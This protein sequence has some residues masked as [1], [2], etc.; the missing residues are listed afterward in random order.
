[1][2]RNI[3]RHNTTVRVVRGIMQDVVKLNKR[4]AGTALDDLLDEIDSL[5]LDE[6]ELCSHKPIER[7]PERQYGELLDWVTTKLYGKPRHLRLVT[8]CGCERDVDLPPD[9]ALGASVAVQLPPREFLHH[10]DQ[11]AGVRLSVYR[12]FRYTDQRRDGRI[13]CREVPER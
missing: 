7:M 5:M 8:L 9:R 10:D 3:E 11:A 13:I 4:W 6:S 12:K 1:M 2:S